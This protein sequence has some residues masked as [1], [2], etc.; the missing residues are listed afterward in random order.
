MSESSSHK[1][2]KSKHWHKKAVKYG[3]ENAQNALNRLQNQ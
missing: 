1:R 3:N 2:A